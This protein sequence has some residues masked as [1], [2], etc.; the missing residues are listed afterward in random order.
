M[1]DAKASAQPAESNAT[2]L[3]SVTAHPKI[4]VRRAKERVPKRAGFS[5]IETPTVDRYFLGQNPVEG[6]G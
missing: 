1:K 6:E 2:R 3:D 5:G 4:N